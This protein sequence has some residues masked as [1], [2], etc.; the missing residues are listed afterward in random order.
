MADIP[1]G[2]SSVRRED[3]ATELGATMRGLLAKEPDESLA[4]I[5]VL[6]VG[7]GAALG[8]RRVAGASPRPTRS[9]VRKPRQRLLHQHF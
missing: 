2:R 7:P 1:T 3:A 9:R 5:G 8:D 4:P 6:S